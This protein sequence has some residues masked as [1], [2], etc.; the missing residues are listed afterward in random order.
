[1]GHG[2]IIPRNNKRKKLTY[3]DEPS[4]TKTN[5]ARTYLNLGTG[6]IS[7]DRV[8]TFHVQFF[9][10]RIRPEIEIVTRVVRNRAL[11]CTDRQRWV[12]QIL[13]R[14]YEAHV[15][16]LDHLLEGGERALLVPLPSSVMLL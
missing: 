8:A 10:V 15:K 11:N 14:Y 6:T 7:S 5:I 3:H 16:D 12:S 4:N 9:G 13:W 2:K 1:M